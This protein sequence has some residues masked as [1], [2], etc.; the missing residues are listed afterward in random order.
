MRRKPA[1]QQARVAKFA[2]TDSQIDTLFDE[3]DHVVT[4]PQIDRQ[5]GV[6]LSKPSKRRSDH[7]Q[8]NGQG[9]CNSQAASRYRTRRFCHLLDLFCIAQQTKR[10]LMQV[11]PLGR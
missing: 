5:L 3:I 1:R 9:R 4:Q 7:M 6:Q 11:A 8:A 10:A 2:D